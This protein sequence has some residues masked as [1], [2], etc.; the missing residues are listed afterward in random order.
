MVQC[1][2]E[3]MPHSRSHLFEEINEITLLF[4]CFTLGEQVI[5]HPIYYMYMS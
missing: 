5:R 2:D 3:I 1:A 4:N